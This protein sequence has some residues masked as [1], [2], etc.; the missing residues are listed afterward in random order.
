MA[1]TANEDIDWVAIAA[2]DEDGLTAAV[3]AAYAMIADQDEGGRHD[4]LVEAISTVYVMPD[5]QLRSMTE[6]RLRAWIALPPEKAAVVGNSFELVMDEMPANLAMRRVTVV[7]SVAFRLKPEE[8]A[9][10]QN[11]APRPRR[12]SGGG[13]TDD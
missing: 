12:H 13:A 11:R 3:T 10:L 6:A 7:Q 1:S 4:S 2:L 9:L 8:L 5:P